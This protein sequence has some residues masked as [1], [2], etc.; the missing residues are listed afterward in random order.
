MRKGFLR[1]RVAIVVVLAMIASIGL[2]VP[3]VSA[4]ASAYTGGA[5]EMPLYMANDH[6]PVALRFNSSA[7]LEANTSYYVKIRFTAAVTPDSATNRGWTWNWT[8]NSWV[9]ERDAWTSFPVITTAADGTIPDTWLYAK[10]G[11]EDE[12]GTYYAMVS[13]SKTGASS[14]FNPT[15]LPPVTVLDMANEG[16]WVHNGTATS[17]SGAKRAEL[18]STDPTTTI[19]GL[20]KTE[21]DSVDTDANG[22]VDGEDYGP[23]G[24]TGDVRF[25]VPLNTA[26]N[27]YLN[28][29]YSTGYAIA[30]SVTSTDTDLALKAADLEAPTAPT[31][32]TALAGS[33]SVEL[34]WNAATDGGGAGIAGYR[35]YRWITSPST[36]YTLPKEVVGTTAGDSPSYVDGDLVKGTEYSYEVRAVDAS[37]NVGPRST[38][39]TCTPVGLMETDRTFGADRYST[40]LAISSANFPDSSVT[41]AVVATGKAFPDALSASALAGVYGSPILLVNSSVTASLTAE[42]DRLGVQDVVI[43][44]GETAVPAGIATAL[45]I[46]YGVTRVFGSDRY[47]TSVAIASKVESLTG[48][49][50]EAFFARGDSFADALAVSPFAYSRTVPVLL[51]RPTEIPAVTAA[52]ID[53]L[54]LTD[55]VI[56]GSESAVSADVMTDLEGM[57]AGTVTRVGGVDRYLTARAVADFGVAQGWGD[58]SY[59]G[60]ATGLN[61]PDALGGGPVAGGRNGVLLLTRP[62]VLSATVASAITDNKDTIDLVDIYGSESAVAATVRTAVEA[63]LQ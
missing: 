25:A 57:L 53:T 52:A 63:L 38:M 33:N 13:L 39:A 59:V 37:T 47:S 41:T 46:D 3:P 62:D 55:G 58:Y 28:R 60:L 23:V 2:A 49:V 7:G 26:F 44:G 34:S 12:S 32:L 29:N 16:G 43:V 48:D 40:A 50:A 18:T 14:T 8:T 51:V 45:A 61:Y 20:S 10:F 36:A 27:V 1:Q 9:Q 4:A 24:A 17:V 54:G 5:W 31:N 11:D 22:T 56:A 35:V 15:L 19:F 21:A 6:T 30:Q 42:L